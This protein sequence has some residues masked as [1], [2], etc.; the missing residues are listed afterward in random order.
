VHRK[1]VFAPE[2]EADLL[3]LYDYIAERSGPVRAMGFIDRLEAYCLGFA[4]RMARPV[5]SFGQ[6]AAGDSI[7]P[8][9]VD[10]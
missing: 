4:P 6:N 8:S 2:A 3:N 10:A 5:G 7:E 9:P 1:V